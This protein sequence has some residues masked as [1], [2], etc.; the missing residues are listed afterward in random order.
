MT[1]YPTNLVLLRVPATIELLF[2][3]KFV[4]SRKRRDL[5]KSSLKKKLKRLNIF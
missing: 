5:S 4:F 3:Y 2:S 1:A